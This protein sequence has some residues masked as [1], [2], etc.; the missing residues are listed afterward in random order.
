LAFGDRQSIE[1]FRKNSKDWSRW[2][3]EYS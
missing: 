3:F 2:L 1:F